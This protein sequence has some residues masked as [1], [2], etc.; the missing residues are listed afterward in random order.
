MAVLEFSMHRAAAGRAHVNAC[1]YR[2]DGMT[3]VLRS[4]QGEKKAAMPLL[5]LACVGVCC[6]DEARE[7]RRWMC[8]FSGWSGGAECG[9]HALRCHEA[10]KGQLHRQEHQWLAK[11]RQWRIVVAGLPC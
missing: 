5:L 7:R 8:G 10:K 1:H 2:S 3:G 4:K 11:L 9:R 6:E